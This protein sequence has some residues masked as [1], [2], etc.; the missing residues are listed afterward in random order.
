MPI[1]YLHIIFCIFRDEN[2]TFVLVY[3]EKELG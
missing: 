2:K 3:L 1:Y